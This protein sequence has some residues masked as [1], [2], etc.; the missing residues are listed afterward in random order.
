M[1][2]TNE[3]PRPA[4]PSLAS[5]YKEARSGCPRVGKEGEG[6]TELLHSLLL[7]PRRRLE[8]Q[9]FAWWQLVEDDADDGR[10][11]APVRRAP[12]PDQRWRW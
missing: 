12:Q 8:M 4:R 1:N 2:S 11:P 10:L 5:P 3:L 6:E 9:G 7:N